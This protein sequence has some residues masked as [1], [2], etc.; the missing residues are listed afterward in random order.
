MGDSVI[1]VPKGVELFSIA[2]AALAMMGVSFASVS[3]YLQQSAA[4]KSRRVDAEA[5]AKGGTGTKLFRRGWAA[6]ENWGTWSEGTVAELD[7][8]LKAKPRSDLSMWID[9]RIYPHFAEPAQSIRVIVNG[10]YV[11]TL[12]RNYEGGLYGARFKIPLQVATVSQ[13]MHVTFEIANPVSP[14]SINDGAD[15]RLLG[16]GLTSIEVDYAM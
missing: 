15:T 14:K 8:Q 10:S 9:G 2:I 12:E 11:A 16:L 7:W 1:A 5:F 13:P 4:A 6:S 3:H